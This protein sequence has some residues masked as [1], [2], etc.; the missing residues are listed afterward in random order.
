[1][2]VW[3][4]MALAIPCSSSPVFNRFWGLKCVF[5]QGRPF[6]QQQK[7]FKKSEKVGGWVGFFSF[8]NL[9]SKPDAFINS[10]IPSFAA[11]HR[12]PPP[13]VQVEPEGSPACPLQGRH[14]F[15]RRGGLIGLPPRCPLVAGSRRPFPRRWWRPGPPWGEGEQGSFW[16]PLRGRERRTSAAHVWFIS[17]LERLCEWRGKSDTFSQSVPQ[18]GRI[19]SWRKPYILSAK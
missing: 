11:R 16:W 6:K 19:D 9:K 15:P 5:K 18:A 7:I 2:W 12:P 3:N 8:L 1:M 14:H 4:K 10:W 17:C 13:P